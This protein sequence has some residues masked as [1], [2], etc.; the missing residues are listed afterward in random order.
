MLRCLA[1][2]LLVLTLCAAIPCAAHA[3]EERVTMKFHG[4]DVSIP[5]LTVLDGAQ[6]RIVLDVTGVDRWNAPAQ[7]DLDGQHLTRLTSAYRRVGGQ[8]QVVI[9]L[10]QPPSHYTIST[11]YEVF[12]DTLAFVVIVEPRGDSPQQRAA[13]H[14][15]P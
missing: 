15:S 7:Q 8:V 1:T 14:K 5:E 2:L 9:G 11:F 3:Q 6:P 4:P 13:P 10:R 12:G